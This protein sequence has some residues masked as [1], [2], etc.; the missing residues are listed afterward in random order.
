M[1]TR[2]ESGRPGAAPRWLMTGLALAALAGCGVS[3]VDTVR[4]TWPPFK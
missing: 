3:T 4:V 2:R 1:T